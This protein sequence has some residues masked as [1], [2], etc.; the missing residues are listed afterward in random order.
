[1][2][3]P[4][5]KRPLFYIVLNLIIINVVILGVMNLRYP[6]VGHDYSITIPGMLDTYLHFHLNGLSIQWFTPTFGGG[7]PAFPNPN[8]GQFSLLILLS[9]ILPPW[10]AVLASTV[11]Y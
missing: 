11:I 10:E 6:E 9:M 2:L 7:I 1:M 4:E 3:M 5:N 8:N